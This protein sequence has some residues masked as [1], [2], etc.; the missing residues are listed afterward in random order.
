MFY[1]GK[2]LWNRSFK[3]GMEE[4]GMMDGVTFVTGHAIHRPPPRINVDIIN[5]MSP[6]RFLAIC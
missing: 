5:F 4:R 2:D 1:G 6:V 3:S